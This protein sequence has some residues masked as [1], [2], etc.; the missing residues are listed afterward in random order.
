MSQADYPSGQQ[1]GP[2]EQAKAYFGIFTLLL[3]IF[4]FPQTVY[5]RLPGSMGRNYFGFPAVISFILYVPFMVL[6]CP[7]RYASELQLINWYWLGMLV[8]LVVHALA[9]NARKRRG[10]MIH[11]RFI[12]E[13]VLSAVP[14]INQ[15]T[16]W[17]W[18]TAA[19]LIVGAIL[20]AWSE[21]LGAAVALSAAADG[22]YRVILAVRD[23]KQ[24][25]AAVDAYLEAETFNERVHERLN[26]RLF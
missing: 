25:D 13:P 2:I 22:L 18:T 12:G 17:F 20:T 15:S 4:S 8:M 16:A 11:S 24:T 19:S 23:E 9:R 5:T 6:L 1:R 3:Q 21:T 10:E 14:G 7:P 26:E